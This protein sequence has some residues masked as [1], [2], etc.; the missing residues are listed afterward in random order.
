MLKTINDIKNSFTKMIDMLNFPAFIKDNISEPISKLK[1]PVPSIPVM[2]VKN[3]IPSTDMFDFNKYPNLKSTFDI[4]GSG[5]DI[6]N[7]LLNPMNE[8]KK[9]VPEITTP[10][11]TS[12]NQTIPEI[13]FPTLD[14]IDKFNDTETTET[15]VIQNGETVII[16][17]ATFNMGKL[18]NKYEVYK[19]II[20][21]DNYYYK[22][23]D[24]QSD[25]TMFSFFNDIDILLTEEDYNK[26]KNDTNSLIQTNKQKIFKILN[27]N[28]ILS[29]EN[30]QDFIKNLVNDN[31]SNISVINNDIKS[32][33]ITYINSRISIF[34]ISGINANLNTILDS[35][36]PN[37]F[38]TTDINNNFVYKS[39]DLLEIKFYI[40]KPTIE[41]DRVMMKFLQ[42]IHDL[43]TDYLVDFKDLFTDFYSTYS[44]ADKLN[45][46]TDPTFLSLISTKDNSVENSNSIIEPP[47]NDV[48]APD[49][50]KMDAE[51]PDISDIKDKIPGKVSFILS[52]TTFIKTI[53]TV[54]INFI[55][56]LLDKLIK[57]IKKMLTL[58]VSGAV[59]DL[60]DFFKNILPS[61]KSLEKTITDLM[62]KS[63][64]QKLGTNIVSFLETIPT[65][66]SSTVVLLTTILKILNGFLF[67]KLS[68]MTQKKIE[69]NTL[70][71]AI[72]STFF[73]GAIGVASPGSLLFVGI[74]TGID[75]VLNSMFSNEKIIVSASG[76]PN[77]L[78]FLTIFS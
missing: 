57:I 3:V 72:Y 44:Q 10:D 30:F 58:N 38:T 23:K 74:K 61:P 71:I 41:Y 9:L 64:L 7:L 75:G 49:L 21:N 51:S 65:I 16:T 24:Q 20:S 76:D 34:K 28:D 5:L 59:S 14:Y 50:P 56:D 62:K 54:P 19:N 60:G 22:M 47:K 43:N 32:D 73:P 77:S 4:S 8:L 15:K 36:T 37:S 42:Q 35:L 25:G 27:D 52:I 48:N 69:N 13:K 11:I 67:K 53:I 33:L 31:Y 55:V 40:A 2:G 78:N 12:T 46:L 17:G 63:G 18:L 39:L 66:I 26:Y 70:N 1:I 6:N 45:L 29:D 68:M